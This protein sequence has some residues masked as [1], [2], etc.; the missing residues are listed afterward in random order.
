MLDEQVTFPKARWKETS[1][2]VNGG[3]PTRNLLLVLSPLNDS[4]AGPNVIATNIYL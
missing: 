1:G 4:A 2:K 3:I